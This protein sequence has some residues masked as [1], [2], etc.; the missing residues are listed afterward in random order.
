[1]LFFPGCLDV[2]LNLVNT[3][4]R[5]AFTVNVYAARVAR[6]SI[7]SKLLPLAWEFIQ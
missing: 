2:G 4:G 5:T 3:S 6:I 1:M 7:S